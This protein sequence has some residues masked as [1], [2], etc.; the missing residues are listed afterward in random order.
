M[1]CA[2][3]LMICFFV[4]R[5]NS[6]IINDQRTSSSWPSNLGSSLSTVSQ[7]LLPS[8]RALMVATMVSSPAR[9][10]RVLSRSRRVMV[11]SWR[12]W[13][14]TVTPKGVPSS[15]FLLYLLPIV[16]DESSTRLEM[17]VAWSFC[18]SFKDVRTERRIGGERN[19]KDLGRGD[20]GEKESTWIC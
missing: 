13:K 5:L 4:F 11:P 18:E 7:V 17:P 19:D 1:T 14:S 15:S 9:T 16:A 10:C 3:A 6:W 20:A 12:V 2:C 8:T